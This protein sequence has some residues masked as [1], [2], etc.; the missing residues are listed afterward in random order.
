MRQPANQGD[1]HRLGDILGV[2]LVESASPGNRPDQAGM[3]IGQ[4]LPGTF[5]ALEGCLNELG[6]IALVGSHGMILPALDSD[7]D[8]VGL[9]RLQGPNPRA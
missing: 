5:A 8:H 9:D 2:R 1:E 7:F 4:F 3:P 6:V